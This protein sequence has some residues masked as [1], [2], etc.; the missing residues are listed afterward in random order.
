M[1]EFILIIVLLSFRYKHSVYILLRKLFKLL[2]KI[3]GIVK[4]ISTK[5]I[6]KILTNLIVACA[7]APTH[8]LNT[9]YYPI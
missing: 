1:L 4:I 2:G 3:N 6:N 7:N 5:T 9:S 8:Y